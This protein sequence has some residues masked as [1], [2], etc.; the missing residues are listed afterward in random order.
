MRHHVGYAHSLQIHRCSVCCVENLEILAEKVQSSEKADPSGVLT[1]LGFASLDGE[2]GARMYSRFESR[3][4]M[5]TF[6]RRTDVLRFWRGS[7]GYIA[8]M[9]QR[10]SLPNGKGWLHRNRDTCETGAAIR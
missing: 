1:F 10:G 6:L 9:E 5:E 4:A 2:E 3:E 8:S 7:K